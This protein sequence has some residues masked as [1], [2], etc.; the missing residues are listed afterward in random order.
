MLDLALHVA[1]LDGGDRTAQLVD[2]LEVVPG[3][4]V[5]TSSV[6]GLDEVRARPAGR[7]CR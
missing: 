1:G 5:S 2:A 4:A 3:A 7:R 6:S